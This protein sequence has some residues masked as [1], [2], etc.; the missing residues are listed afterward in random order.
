MLAGEFE[1]AGPLMTEFES[2]ARELYTGEA[3][4]FIASRNAEARRA[5]AAGDPALA[6][7]I[8]GLRKPTVAAAIVNR[9]TL[10]RASQLTALIDVGEKLREAHSALAGADIRALTRRRHDLVKQLLSAAPRMRDAVAREVEATLEAAV[11]DPAAAREAASGKLSTALE[12]AAENVW[13]TA[14]TP[15]GPPK[16][17]PPQRASSKSSAKEK[18]PESAP[19]ES[20]AQQRRREQLR[21]QTDQRVKARDEAEA[22]LADAERVETETAAEAD[23][24]RKRL[25]EAE[26]AARDARGIADTARATVDRS[27]KAA[28]RAQEK[29]EAAGSR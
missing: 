14:G 19:R 4:E 12:P 22:E 20:A 7:R 21:L 17:A 24:L 1:K 28:Q 15:T 25:A 23:R 5:K 29:L 16:S 6:E 26:Q 10:T 3:A 27:R 9:L 13:L 18:P 2:I 11:A 8:R